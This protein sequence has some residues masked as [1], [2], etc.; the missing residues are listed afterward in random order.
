MELIT[1]IEIVSEQ[2]IIEKKNSKFLPVTD[3]DIFVYMYK[4]E[5]LVYGSHK[6]LN[7]IIF[8][9]ET[10]HKQILVCFK[11]I[12]NLHTKNIIYELLKLSQYRFFEK[13]H[14]SSC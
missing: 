6:K 7:A 5:R 3:I 10:T 2:F 13:S 9:L 1:G 12:L 14:C 11:N 4:K 8:R